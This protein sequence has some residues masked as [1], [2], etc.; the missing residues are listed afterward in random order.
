MEKG[1]IDGPC[2]KFCTKHLK[3]TFKIKDFTEQFICDS[4]SK[5]QA[6]PNLSLLFLFH[7][8]YLHS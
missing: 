4:K 1:Q 8:K 5:L 3:T 6:K 2:F 7:L